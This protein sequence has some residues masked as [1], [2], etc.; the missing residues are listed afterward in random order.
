MLRLFWSTSAVSRSVGLPFASSTVMSNVSG[1]P[2]G[3]YASS[4][5][6]RGEPESTVSVS[7]IGLTQG[8]L[9]VGMAISV[10]AE[11]L[12]SVSPS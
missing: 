3:S 7:S 5:M 12:S 9:D 8:V 10:R 1:S 6:C 2:L 11:I 4:G